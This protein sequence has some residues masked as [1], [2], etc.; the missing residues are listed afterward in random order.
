MFWKNKNIYH[1]NNDV[2]NFLLWYTFYLYLL[3]VDRIC[4]NFATTT[5]QMKVQKTTRKSLTIA[6]RTQKQ[7]SSNLKQFKQFSM[8]TWK[9]LWW[10]RKEN[11]GCM[12]GIWNEK[13]YVFMQNHMRKGMIFIVVFEGKWGRIW[14]F[15][16][17][18]VSINYLFEDK[19]WIK[20]KEIKMSS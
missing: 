1:W 11:V 2:L 10:W 18:R 3:P 15:I 5:A 7:P 9:L 6:M 8:Q 12:I 19:N 14:I 17:Y 13:L 20:L 16:F 4:K